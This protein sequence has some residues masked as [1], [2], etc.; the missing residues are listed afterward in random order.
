MLL[1]QSTMTSPSSVFIQQ[2]HAGSFIIVSGSFGM[3]QKQD[4]L[5]TETSTADSCNDS[6]QGA[7]GEMNSYHAQQ[8]VRTPKMSSQTSDIGV[9][10]E[11]VIIFS[12]SHNPL[13]I[14]I[15]RDLCGGVHVYRFHQDGVATR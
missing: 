2:E 3:V 6:Q 15:Q 11:V 7:T 4:F 5:T 9:E 8:Q 14:T 12:V 13:F 1:G 10:Q